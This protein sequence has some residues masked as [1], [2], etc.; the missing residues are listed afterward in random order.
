ML[1]R[2]RGVHKGRPSWKQ[3]GGVIAAA[4]PICALGW[5]IWTFSH[6]LVVLGPLDYEYLL[7][8]DNALSKIANGDKATFKAARIENPLVVPNA[9]QQ[10]FEESFNATDKRTV[11]SV[12]YLAITNA[13]TQEVSK[14]IFDPA[15]GVPTQFNL[16]AGMT[17]L[18]CV[19]VAPLDS[20][21]AP[22]IAQVANITCIGPHGQS[23]LIKPNAIPD[24]TAMDQ[25]PGIPAFHGYAK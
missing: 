3:L 23:E 16:R 1:R 11:E 19:R 22:M 24:E 12:T 25:I 4:V 2:I 13:G 5:A 7:F 15:S 20:H 6:P 9:L 10:K 21:N 14:V 8:K 18:V 17:L